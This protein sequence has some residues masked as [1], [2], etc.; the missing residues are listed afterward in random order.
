M[1]DAIASS[2]AQQPPPDACSSRRQ[3][4]LGNWRIWLLFAVVAVIAGRPL[5]GAGWSPL[6]SRRSSLRCFR[7]PPCAPWGF[8]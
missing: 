2:V 8:A 6:A 3:S 1:T 7:A 5:A 4:L